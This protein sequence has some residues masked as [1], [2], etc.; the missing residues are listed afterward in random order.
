MKKKE[1]MK[2]TA[3]V[4]KAG[5]GIMC[6]AM[7][8]GTVSASVTPEKAVG[9]MKAAE[10]NAAETNTLETNAAGMNVSEMDA[11]GIRMDETTGR[12]V[13]SEAGNYT[14]T[15]NMKG[16]VFVDPGVGD[17]VLTLDNVKID[18]VHSAGIAAVSGD[19]LTIRMAD[20]SVN[21]ICDGGQDENYTAAVYS[22]TDLTFE[23]SGVLNIEANN[24]QAIQMENAS[25]FFDG[26]EYRIK[27]CG[28]G[29]CISG[30]KSGSITMNS[31]S[32]YI[33]A[34]GNSIDPN[35]NVVMNG[36]TIVEDWDASEETT[37]ST[38]TAKTKAAASKERRTGTRQ[39]QDSKSRQ[40]D[41]SEISENSQEEKSKTPNTGSQQNDPS[42]PQ[43]EISQ[44]PNTGSQQNDPSAPQGKKGRNTNTAGN[45]TQTGFPGSMQGNMQGNMSQ[46]T[47]TTDTAGEIVTGTAGSSAADLV[48]DYENAVTYTMTDEENEVKIDESGTYIVTGSSSNGSITVKKET[49]GVVLV[50]EDLDLTS[51]SGA[52]L[53]INKSAE[54]Q[55]IVSGNVTLTDNE[56]PEDEN[57]TDA[58]V[59]DAYDGAAFK[60]KANSVVF[61]TGDGNLTINGNAK[62]GIKGGDDSSLV[63]VGDVTVDIN[64]VNDGINSN[65]DVTLLAGDIIIN[66]GDDAV[67]ADHILTSG[68]EDGTG[69]DLDI[70]SSTEGLEGTVVNIFG[71]DIDITSSDDAVNAANGDGVYEGVLD[72]SFNMTGGDLTINAA[73][74]GIDSNGN[75]NLID[76][77][78]EI[79]SGAAA[80]EAGIDYI[81]DLYISEDFELENYNGVASDAMMGRPMGGNMPAMSGQNGNN[82]SMPAM[83]GQNGNNGSMPA[84]SGQD[85]NSGNSGSMLAMPDQD[86]NNG[87]LLTVSGQN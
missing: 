64:A 30:D 52:A 3:F 9:N 34:A 45:G 20:G 43:G 4:K 65:Y 83:S 55:V 87:V 51:T 84:M 66:A 22:R 56:N 27:S 63:I 21:K 49:T 16:T 47:G 61:V 81:G 60:L 70:E 38:G 73:G 85:G 19:S 69:P 37:V 78:A 15:G 10:A 33:H 24:R 5:I 82:G 77:E 72:Y 58:D 11:E 35:T 62:N 39:G 1:Q 68:S 80:G 50:L 28:T 67:H 26:G 53:S 2:K 32:V 79:H 54:V 42:A 75:I 17:V 29:I 14:L 74:D 71:G 18:G 13:I 23:G 8:A 86:G 7:A 46:T 57:S 25:V 40:T 12:I 31:G 44:N 59:A 48:A 6:A 36:G 41:N 76:G